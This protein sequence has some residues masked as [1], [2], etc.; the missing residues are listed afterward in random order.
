MFRHLCSPFLSLLGPDVLALTPFYSWRRVILRLIGNL[1]EDLIKSIDILVA[2]G[3]LS[4][5]IF[6]FAIGDSL[7]SSRSDNTNPQ[8]LIKYGVLVLVVVLQLVRTSSTT[9]LQCC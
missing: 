7:L 5:K 1:A 9:K 3:G 8:R 2:I 6:L 4:L